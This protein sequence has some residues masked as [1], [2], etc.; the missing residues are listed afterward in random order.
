M[1]RTYV[2]NADLSDL[3]KDELLLAMSYVH[4]GMS[5]SETS[6]QIKALIN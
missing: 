3:T 1:L 2:P 5:R 4:S 6:A